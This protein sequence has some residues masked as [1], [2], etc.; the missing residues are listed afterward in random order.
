MV[1]PSFQ[2]QAPTVSVIEAPE[3][4]LTLELAKAHINVEHDEKDDLIQSY[5]D[6]CLAAV[7]G[8]LGILGRAIGVQTLEVAVWQRC[9]LIVDL[10]CPPLIEVLSVQ[11]DTATGDTVDVDAATWRRRRNA[12]Q[13]SSGLPEYDELRI[14]FTAGYAP[15]GGESPYT[16]HPV[17]SRARLGVLLM[18]GSMW[19]NRE[20][21]QPTREALVT[22]P[23][24]ANLLPSR[25]QIVA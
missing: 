18:V 10:P 23:A 7:D 19:A 2:Q 24:V 8:P 11:Y 3:P 14:R 16:E 9:G 5:V 15:I 4:W 1:R 22:N 13:F 25:V 21:E 6:G 17:V 20:G 12:V